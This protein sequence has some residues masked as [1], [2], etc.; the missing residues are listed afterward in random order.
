MG[1]RKK[2]TKRIHH[3]KRINH[4]KISSNDSF[5]VYTF[6][7]RRLN[8]D[9]YDSSP[10]HD[11]QDSSIS[12]FLSAPTHPHLV[13]KSILDFQAYSYDTLL[14][15]AYQEPVAAYMGTSHRQKNK[16]AM[17]SAVKQDRTVQYNE[18]GFQ[19]HFS[20]AFCIPDTGFSDDND[21]YKSHNSFHREQ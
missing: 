8:T 1:R 3:H 2:K 11:I 6:Q 14:Y 13:L 10:T 17:N 15:I 20:E 16:N 21:T 7:T 19:N 5:I 4:P 12:L 9:R 18:I